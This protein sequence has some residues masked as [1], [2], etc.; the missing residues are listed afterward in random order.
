MVTVNTC[1]EKSRVLADLEFLEKFVVESTPEELYEN[2]S[3]MYNLSAR[4]IGKIKGTP[5]E[6]LKSR[7]LAIVN[8]ILK[9]LPGEA[10]ETPE[11]TPTPCLEGTPDVNSRLTSIENILLQTLSCIQ[12]QETTQDEIVQ[13]MKKIERR[14]NKI[15][16][17]CVKEL[18]IPVI[19]KIN[20]SILAHCN[21]NC[22]GC[23]HF[24]PLADKRIVPTEV[25]RK[26]LYQMA[27]ITDGSVT[28]L[29]IFGGEPLLHPNF[30]EIIKDAKQAFPNAKIK[31]LTNGVLL[32]SQDEAFWVACHDNDIEL[33]VTKYPINLDFEKIEQTAREYN[34]EYTYFSSSGR[35]EKTLQKYPL[36]VLGTQDP[37]KNFAN[38]CLSHNC[39]VIREG[40]LYYCPVIA[41]SASFNKQFGTNM[42]LDKR[43]YLEIDTVE[44]YD[45]LLTFLASPKPFCRYCDT[46]KM[47]EDLP[48]EL[49]KRKMSE[50]V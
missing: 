7:Y 30:K 43:D 22:K 14:I 44:S 20:F 33:T 27:K 10:Q 50:W 35:V 31:V 15:E 17:I 1:E 37:R 12:K 24:A 32:P 38:C 45:Q 18:P 46:K 42:I 49:S 9:Y 40:K 2:S 3:S 48:W 39:N 21:L 23:S 25:I 8:S 29:H 47:K 5:D 16:S 4:N 6:H 36:D 19:Y 13:K 28:L 11:I 41:N 26:D 34:V